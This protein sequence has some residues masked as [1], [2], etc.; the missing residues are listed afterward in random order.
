MS[1]DRNHSDGKVRKGGRAKVFYSALDGLRG[2]A[3]ICVVLFHLANWGGNANWFPRGDLA[4]DFFF[5]LSGFVLAHAYSDRLGKSMSYTD[6]VSARFIRLYPLLLFSVVLASLYFFGKS[7]LST[8]LIPTTDIVAAT[9]SASMV[10]PYLESSVPLSGEGMAFPINGPLWSLFFE[11][12]ISFVWAGL[13]AVLTF[14]R[15]LAAAYICA[16]V[17]LIGGLSFNDLL[18]GDETHNFLWGIPRVGVSFA[19]GLIVHHVNQQKWCTM[20]WPLWVICLGLVAPLMVPRAFG[21]SDLLVDAFFIFAVSP[22]IVLLGA[23]VTLEGTMKKVS[24]I[25]G[26]LSYP[27]YVLH[28]PIFAWTNGTLQTLG[29]SLP[30]WQSVAL[31]FVMIMACSWVAL[32]AYDRPVRRLLRQQ[33]KSGRWP[34]AIQSSVGRLFRRNPAKL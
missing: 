26:E 12:F 14:R 29:V 19:L 16:F 28:F 8:E 6:F 5:C 15:T 13:F 7:L 11:F 3:A 31:Y 24:D 32:I 25:G 30:I 17:L 21:I 20:Q 34:V 23:K 18:L 9:V 22:F 10:L 4:V 27:I 33:Q 2:I 1:E